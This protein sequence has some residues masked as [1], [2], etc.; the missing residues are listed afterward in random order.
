MKKK[1]ATPKSSPKQSPVNN[2][3]LKAQ[4]HRLLLRLQRGPADTLLLRREENIL[5]PAAR[6]K[7]L[8]E[9]GYVIVT[10]LVTLIDDYGR[11]HN[12]I[13]RYTLVKQG[14]DSGVRACQQ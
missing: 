4:R 3:S 12:R 6:V 5:M 8:R 14:N 1:K 11:T 10:D 13:A 7:N 2:T 9:K